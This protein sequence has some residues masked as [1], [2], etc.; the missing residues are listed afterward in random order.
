MANDAEQEWQWLADAFAALGLPGRFVE[1]DAVPLL[2]FHI[3]LADGWWAE[4][5][6]GSGDLRTH[7]PLHDPLRVSVRGGR[8]GHPGHDEGYGLSWFAARD[9]P[10]DIPAIVAPLL[11]RLRDGSAPAPTPGGRA[12]SSPAAAQA[13]LEA[14]LAGAW[15]ALEVWTGFRS[16]SRLPVE[17]YDPAED[18][19]ILL[20]QTERDDH[21]FFRIGLVRQFATGEG[22]EGDQLLEQLEC[23]IAVEAIDAPSASLWS[24]GSDREEFWSRAAALPGVGEALARDEPAVAIAVRLDAV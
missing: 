6:T 14:T 10:T 20:V 15:T 16:F 19:D 3:D 22:D 7:D 11:H 18:A 2:Q 21:G 8:P 12:L 5:S 13:L 1:Y 23:E 17:G 4:V 9:A 24:S